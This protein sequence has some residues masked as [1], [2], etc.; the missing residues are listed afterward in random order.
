MLGASG[1][2]I[3]LAT[4]N[5]EKY[6][7]QQ[8]MSL[9]GQTVEDWTCWIR[10]DGS[11]DSTVAIVRDWCAKDERFRLVD[12]GRPNLGPAQNFGVLLEVAHAQGAECVFLCDQDDVWSPK[13]LE[14]QLA[15]L[16]RVEG[17]NKGPVLIHSDL[18]VVDQDLNT[19]ARSF[20]R[21]QYLRF[22]P[23]DPLGVLL[24]QNFV[25]GCAAV[26]NRSL[27][28]LALP[29]PTDVIMHDW[30][31]A[32]VAAAAGQVGFVELPTLRYRQHTSNVL[33]AQDFRGRLRRALFG[34]SDRRREMISQAKLL[35]RRLHAHEL[36]SS[37][38]DSL[39]SMFTSPD[40]GVRMRGL[41]AAHI[42]RSLVG[43]KYADYLSALLHA[44][45]ES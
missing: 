7:D 36:N 12:D 42:R 31:L 35:S 33:G 28:D 8:L 41:R 9:V 30:W 39:I 14:L 3:V 44:T 15:E 13:K 16:A 20:L 27:L 34:R 11:T 23:E 10:D 22:E 2:H 38:V 19:V 32:Q 21:Q 40:R 17:P 45:S 25:T 18:E 43:V 6:L 5:G 1:T 24:M 26:V 29:V 4:Y 37:R